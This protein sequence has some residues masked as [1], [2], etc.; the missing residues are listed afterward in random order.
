MTRTTQPPRP[1][2]PFRTRVAVNAMAVGVT[3]TAGAAAYSLGQP[4]PIVFELAPAE[5]A[6]GVDTFTHH[7]GGTSESV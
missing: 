2:M 3:V 6:G 7:T 4:A 1:L 5:T